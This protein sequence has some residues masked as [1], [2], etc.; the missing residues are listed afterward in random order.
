MNKD[1]AT[2]V[3]IKCCDCN[4]IVLMTN[5]YRAICDSCGRY[6][7]ISKRKFF[8]VTIPVAPGPHEKY[9]IAKE[10]NNRL[11]KIA[12]VEEF[13]ERLGTLAT[14]TSFTQYRA[15]RMAR[16]KNGKPNFKLEKKLVSWMKRETFKYVAPEYTPTEGDLIRG[17]VPSIIG[18]YL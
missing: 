2:L 1:K 3:A 6:V 9:Q 11:H 15:D 8:D 4:N 12:N 5:K 14:A 16:Y 7:A 17:L 10:Y 13:I 18:D